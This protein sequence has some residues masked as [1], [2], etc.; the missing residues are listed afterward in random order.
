MKTQY[1][2]ATSLDG[3]IA[4][5]DD[6]LEW[7]FPL[8]DINDT[9]YP[10]FIAQVGALAM[11]SATY[12]WMLRHSEKVAEEAGSAWPYTQPAWVFTRRRLP[13]I[14]GADIRFV[15]G[16][17]RPVHGE[18]SRAAGGRNLWIVGGGDLAGQFHDAGLLD[19]AIIQVASVTLGK[20]KSLFPRRVTS[21]PWQL[22][23][24]RQVGAGFAEL[25]YRLP[26]S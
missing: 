21:P 11:G 18:M 5:E 9:S 17:V 26:Q 1:Y 7:L 14:G 4:T 23:S 20:G 10:A 15:Q 8:G 6:S 13:T 3:F 24:V 19:E 25:H 12:E 22:L 16:D 2:T